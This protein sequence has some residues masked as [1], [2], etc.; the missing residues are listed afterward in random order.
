MGTRILP[1]VL[2]ISFLA[3]TGAAIAQ[4]SVPPALPAN[5]TPGIVSPTDNTIYFSNASPAEPPIAP[6]GD[7]TTVCNYQRET[8]SLMI[9]RVCRTL[10]AWKLMQTEARDYMEFGFRGGSQGNAPHGGGAGS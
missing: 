7:D 1:A 2:A 9:T 8:G 5:P 4:T 10:R 3:A 6:N